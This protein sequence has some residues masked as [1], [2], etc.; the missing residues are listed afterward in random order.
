MLFKFSLNLLFPLFFQQLLYARTGAEAVKG[1]KGL[2]GT[3]KCEFGTIN[4]TKGGMGMCCG[5]CVSI[6]AFPG[7]TPSSQLDISAL[8]LGCDLV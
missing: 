6:A 5:S 3:L 7:G 1:A 2:P 8:E 4:D